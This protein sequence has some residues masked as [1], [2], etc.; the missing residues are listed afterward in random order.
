MFFLAFTVAVIIF[1]VAKVNVLV[2]PI[3]FAYG[4]VSPYLPD[5]PLYA[6]LIFVFV[7]ILIFGAI[8]IRTTA[9]S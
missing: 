4:L 7:G 5:N 1:I 3:S 9:K 6:S 8:L 2:I